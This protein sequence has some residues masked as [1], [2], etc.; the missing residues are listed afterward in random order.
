MTPKLIATA[1]VAVFAGAAPAGADI[2][3]EVVVRFASPVAAEQRAEVRSAERVRPVDGLYGGA[4]VV[5]VETGRSPEEA[6][7]ALA[8]RPEVLWATPNFTMELHGAPNDPRFGEQWG[9]H[10]TGQAVGNV[11]GK[12]DADVDAPEAWELTAGSTDVVVAILDSGVH[13]GHPDLAPRVLPGYDFLDDDADP[14]D[15]QG[16]GTSTAGTAAGRGNDGAGVTGVAQQAT[17]LPVRVA[18]RDGA[19]PF[20]VYLEG[21]RYGAEHADVVNLSL[22]GPREPQPGELEV[23]QA[24]PDVLFVASAGNNGQV[25]DAA[26]PISPCAI[27]APNVVCVGASGQ[28][29]AVTSFS[30]RGPSLVDLVAP[31]QRILTPKA[32]SDVLSERFDLPLAGRW[33][34]AGD[35]TWARSTVAEGGLTP[36][37]LAESPN[38]DYADGTNA[39]IE[40]TGSLVMDLSD[41]EVCRFGY[42]RDIELADAGDAVFV[43]LDDGVSMTP[44]TIHEEHETTNGQLFPPARIPS[45]I[46]GKAGVTLRLRFVSDGAGTAAGA[47]VDNLLVDCVATSFGPQSFLLISGTSFSAPMV[48]GAAV[49][50]KAREPGVTAAGMRE[51]LLAGVD[52]RPSLAGL[53]GSGG[54]LNAHG[55]LLALDGLL[56]SAST[57]AADAVTP[58]GATL[59]GAVD[60]HGRATTARFEYGTTAAYGATVPAAAAGGATSAAIGGLAPSTTYHYRLVAENAMGSRHGADRTFTTPPTPVAETTPATTEAAP[61]PVLPPARRRAALRGVTAPSS[62]RLRGRLLTVALRN[63]NRQTVTGTLIAETARPRAVAAATG[64]ALAPLALS[65][66][67]A[68]REAIRLGRV[69]F[70]I[71]AGRTAT[72]RFRLTRKGASRARRARRVT[73]RLVTRRPGAAPITTRRTLR[74]RR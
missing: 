27:P 42:T 59:R 21:L 7:A 12:A 20:D 25:I 35:A 22:G 38:A 39:G 36:P 65:A 14:R 4:Q 15:E 8:A 60:P 48:S 18:D 26:N 67:D 64:G 33:V 3:R 56:P 46:L 24:F 49:L 29:D 52:E 40:T 61:P 37:F 69:T 19:I 63:D 58:A 53:V 70:R 68:A 30:N 11:S 57:E 9:L 55:A 34:A 17:I 51:A 72:V 44:T 47:V 23:V 32:F 71:A 6:A 41:R 5:R 45:S 31:G 54:R 43:E 2:D 16:H 74:L 10:N 66:A 28:T 1:V 73:L 13:A 50:L 62:A